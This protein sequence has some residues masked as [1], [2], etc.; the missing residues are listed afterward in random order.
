MI[1]ATSAGWARFW[2]YH[3]PPSRMQ[4]DLKPTTSA[5]PIFCPLKMT[6]SMM[7]MPRSFGSRGAISRNMRRCALSVVTTDTSASLRM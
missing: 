6:P 7:T 1:E 3:S 4:S 2:S 5:W